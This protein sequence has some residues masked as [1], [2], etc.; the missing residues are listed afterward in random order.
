MKG[1]YVVI[2]VGLYVGNIVGIYV[3]VVVDIVGA[4]IDWHVGECVSI[5]GWDVADIVCWIVGDL[6]DVIDNIFDGYMVEILERWYIDSLVHQLIG[7]AVGVIVGAVKPKFD[8]NTV[9]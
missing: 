9:G 3:S 6:L 4:F 1:L 7:L 8:V 2:F 5:F